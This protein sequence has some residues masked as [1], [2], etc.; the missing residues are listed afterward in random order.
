M[1]ITGSGN[2]ASANIDVTLYFACTV[3]LSLKYVFITVNGRKLAKNINTAIVDW[4]FARNN[5][6]TYQIMKEHAF[7]S[8]LCTL[9]MLYSAYI[10]GGLYILVVIGVN[11]KD[12]FLQKQ[13]MNV[14]NDDVDTKNRLFIIPCGEFGN[15]I[16]S[17]QY[18][19]ILII[20]F[21]QLIIICTAQSI[22]DSFY[23]NV[24]LH[25]SG[26]LNVLKTK[27]KTFANKPESQT[28]HRK[29]FINL[30]NRHCELMELHQNLEGTFHPII[31]SQ[32]VITTISIALLGLR[33]IFCL[34]SNNYMEFIKSI[35][36]LNY[37]FMQ[38]L[39]Y[40]Y[41]GDFVQKG[42]EG[43]FHAMF[44]TSWFT[45]PT[46]LMKDINFAMMKS[47]HSFRFTGGKFFY[48]NRETMIYILKTAASYVS[49]LRIALKD[50]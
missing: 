17:M 32:L 11:L 48:V 47:S 36:V 23:I 2:D 29:K 14:S 45:L 20:Q 10:C 40:C 31:L 38:A 27:F 12:I 13:M 43:I 50:Y 46:T 16:T 26:Q 25:L 41:G 9:I 6:K 7:Q 49:V 24:S 44:T 28:N 42:S 18:A 33:I 35:F 15:K 8:K 1:A 19:I 3:A 30:V 4:S 21:I 22:A 5:K 37:L 39:L 34:K